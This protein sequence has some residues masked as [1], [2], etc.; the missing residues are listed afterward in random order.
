M[1]IYLDF[2]IQLCTELQ[3]GSEEA[4]A[5]VFSQY[6]R[7]LYAL[8]Y[9]FLK[10][11][12]EAEDAVQYTFMKLWE[13]RKNLDF[14][15]GVR[16]LLYTIMKNHIL[17]ELRHRNLVYEKKYQIA[18]ETEETDDGF[19]RAYEEQNLREQLMLAINKLPSQKSI[20]CIMKLKKGLSNQEIA[21]QMHI[22]VATVKSHYTQAIK[23]LRQEFVAVCV[24]VMA[25]LKVGQY[26]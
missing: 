13:E 19:L 7:L 11:G 24:C 8:A 25:F 1:S 23:M 16:S 22:T 9:R 21:D 2:D 5:K 26:L 6:S 14:R 3:K 4:F 10:S 17:N 18:Q 12:E 15:N 20:I